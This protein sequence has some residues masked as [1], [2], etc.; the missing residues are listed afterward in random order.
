MRPIIGI[1]CSYENDK[2]DTPKKYKHLIKEDYVNAIEDAGGIPILLPSTERE[3]IIFTYADM[4]NGLLITGSDDMEPGFYNEREEADAGIK[5]IDPKRT[6]F[7][8]KLYHKAVSR[9]IPIL[10]ICGGHQLINV[11][12][13]GT[14]YQDILLQL[15][16]SIQHSQDDSYPNHIIEIK[17][18]TRLHKIIGVTSLEVNSNHHQSIKDLAG[19][20]IVNATASDRI[21]EGIEGTNHRFIMGLQFHPENLYKEKEMFRRIFNEFI[22]TSSDNNNLV[23]KNVH[24]YKKVY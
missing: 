21:I 8:L 2:E 9:E 15:P 10:G 24:K 1:T 17:H 20:F 23:T 5:G 12:G 13:G 4:I 6:I 11:A 22:K 3:D 14:L 19:G 18:S 16:N 7:E